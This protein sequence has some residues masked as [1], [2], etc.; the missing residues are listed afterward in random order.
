MNAKTVSRCAFMCALSFIILYLSVIVDTLKIVMLCIST[1]LLCLVVDKDGIKNALI[2]YFATSLILYFLLPDK[3]IAIVYL[4]SFGN[5]AIVKYFIENIRN[6]KM[7]IIIKF[8]VINIYFAIG[9]FVS[10]FFINFETIKIP[11]VAL[12]I[13]AYIVF[14]ICDWAISYLFSYISIRLSK[15]NFW[16]K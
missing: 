8:L 2:T 5:Y 16:R 14:F 7:E 15:L 4:I 10:K 11:M 1:A 3:F 9:F 13:L 6:F 12:L